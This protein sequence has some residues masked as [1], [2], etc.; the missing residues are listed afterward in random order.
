MFTHKRPSRLRVTLTD[1]NGIRSIDGG[2]VAGD[3]EVLLGRRVGRNLTVG[4]LLLVEDS[5]VSHHEP[6]LLQPTLNGQPHLIA[7]VGELHRHPTPRLEHPMVNSSTT[8]TA[9]ATA[10]WSRAYASAMTVE[11][12]RGNRERDRQREVGRRPTTSVEVKHGVPRQ[13]SF[14]ETRS[15]PSATVDPA[16]NR[17]ARP[18]ARVIR[19]S[20]ASRRISGVAITVTR[21]RERVT[22]V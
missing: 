14:P 11:T 8:T 6:G 3:D 4:E 18:D 15:H 5:S 9:T 20:I 12:E 13:P 16:A 22:A 21:D 1:L 7:V 2:L 10:P 19:R 17:S